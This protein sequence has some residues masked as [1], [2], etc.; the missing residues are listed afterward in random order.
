MARPFNDTVY[1]ELREAADRLGVP[2]AIQATGR[3]SGTDADAMI[4]SGAGTATGIVSIP[5]RYMHSP[6]EVVSLND[7]E[8]ASRVIA[9]FISS[10]S[11]DSDFRPGSAQTRGI[12]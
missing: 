2:Y 1:F 9:E 11:P 3:S 7:L 12:D 10:L 4:R 6:N 5:N 8:N